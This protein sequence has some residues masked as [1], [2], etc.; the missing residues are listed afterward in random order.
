MNLVAFK[1]GNLNEQVSQWSEISEFSAKMKSTYV[2]TFKA[3]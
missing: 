2:I 1:Q 3:L